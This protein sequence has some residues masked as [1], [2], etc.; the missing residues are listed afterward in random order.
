MNCH[1]R[2]RYR[3]RYRNNTR[4]DAIRLYNFVNDDKLGQSQW[5]KAQY[6][7]HPVHRC[8][9]VRSSRTH[10]PLARPKW[11]ELFCPPGACALFL[12]NGRTHR[13]SWRDGAYTRTV[14]VILNPSGG[15]GQVVY[16]DDSLPR[17][18]KTFMKLT[19]HQRT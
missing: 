16:V 10:I 15:T 5:A 6:G 8:L 19:P 13:A 4:S 14:Q 2:A 3:G 1:A 11:E 17:P 9:E 7:L 12:T 18:P